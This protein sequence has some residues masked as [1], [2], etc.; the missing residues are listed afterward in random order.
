VAEP[1]RI[2]PRRSVAF[3]RHHRHIE[4]VAIEPPAGDQN[5]RAEIIFVHSKNDA[6]QP[7]H[8]AQR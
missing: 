7:H 2:N 3:E 6:E 4:A 1:A 5:P 8:F